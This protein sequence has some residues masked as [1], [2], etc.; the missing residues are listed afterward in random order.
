[1]MSIFSL[2]LHGQRSAVALRG[3][4][5]GSAVFLSVAAHAQTV[6]VVM[7][8]GLRVIDPIV[9]TAYMTRDHGYMIYDTLL[10]VDADFT[11][12]PQMASWQ[13]SDDGKT[14]TFTLREGLI[15][16][17]GAPVTAEDCVAS[18]QR[19][20]QVDAAGQVL[21]TMVERI[22]TLDARRFVVQLTEPTTLLLTALSQLTSRTPFMMPKRIAQTPATTPI[23]ETIGSGPFKFV[24]SEFQPGLKAVYEKNTAYVP[25]SEPA[26]WTAGGKL[27][28]VDRVEWVSMPDQMTAVN[29]LQNGEVDY[30][31][32]VPFDLLPLIQNRSD[33]TV[34][35]L[36]KLGALTYLRLNHLQP[37]FN[38]KLLRQAA[39]AAIAQEDVLKA[40]VGNPDYYRTCA[41]V[42]GCGTPYSDAYGSDW[43]VP[44]RL[45]EAQ[46]LLK[47]ANYDGAPV[48]ILQPTDIAM[49]A[50]QPIVVGAA[51]RRAGF[52]VVMKSMDW[53][54]VV[55]LRENPRPVA[56]GG[57]S[58]F[59]SYSILADSGN[60]ISSSMVAAAGRSSW[61]GWPD[62]PEVERLRAQFAR[63]ADPA[64]RLAI[65]R[66]LQK[67]VIDEVIF[68]PLGQFL[69]PS[70]FSAKLS[71]VPE[72]PVTI[73]WGLRKSD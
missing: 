73:F 1:M 52:N 4:L 44:A 48:V 61:V 42:F 21:M 68:V 9:T 17:D 55:T 60:P 29:A 43:V 37:P 66:Q 22:Q 64:A 36:D 47:A 6:T 67:L 72:S 19:W 32:E 39:M 69:R 3:A 70:A 26:S 65:T 11:V 18:I 54:S 31:Q 30:I 35:V 59:S 7:Q 28:H 56:E 46:R 2:I 41:A 13:V 12:Q 51:L 49:L 10:G 63:A 58:G 71:G 25:R 14:Y 62:V 57:W 24:A 53:Q 33:L 27:V 34:Q 45:D 40:L 50:A 23:T 38:N 8:S 5:F 20:A 16:H 15:W